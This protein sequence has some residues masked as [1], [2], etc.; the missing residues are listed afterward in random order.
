MEN[1]NN[2]IID[3]PARR[4]PTISQEFEF[5]S[6]R[7]HHL[8]QVATTTLSEQ[9]P[10][11]LRQWEDYKQPLQLILKTFSEVSDKSEEFWYRAVPFF[12]REEYS[13][14]AVLYD[15]DDRPNGFY[16][17]EDGILKAEYKLQQGKFSELI[18]AGTTCGELPFFSGTNRTSTTAAETDC[19]TWVLDEANWEVLQETQ[20]D[21]AQELLKISL[22]LTSE[23]MDAITKYDLES[24]C[25]AVDT[26]FCS[27][28]HVTDQWMIVY[29]LYYYIILVGFTWGTKSHN[30][31]GI[32]AA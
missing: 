13:A 21:V 7:R 23:R 28:I 30:G 31:G 8:H 2:N 16:L 5:H 12:I 4:R 24:L 10:A 27:Q 3:V 18:V 25:M 22:K 1:I 29:F 15:R 17:L 14:G 11:P 9:D 26:N 32:N 20:L 6:P 19:V